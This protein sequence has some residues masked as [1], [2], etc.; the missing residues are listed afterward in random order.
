MTEEAAPYVARVLHN[1]GTRVLALV[2]D[3]PLYDD[4]ATGFS[5]PAIHGCPWLVPGENQVVLEVDEAPKDEGMPNN[6]PMFELSFFLHKLKIEEEVNV[7]HVRYPNFAETLP[8]ER[9]KFPIVSDV[10]RF[11]PEGYIPDPIWKDAPSM[12]I[13]AA[14]TPKLLQPLFELH[15]AYERR[16]V[17]AFLDLTSTKISDMVRYTGPSPDAS[18]DELAKETAEFFAMPWD[19]RPFDPN[20][21]RFRSCAQGRVAYVT[22]DERGPALFAQHKTEP[23]TTWPV[24]PYLFFEGTRWR[25][26][27]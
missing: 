20:K 8:S 18:R 24:K 5:A 14:G 11:T 15:R 9:R 6:L 12:N 4:A 7:F 17:D 10:M 1:P 23:R 21:L 3:V 2:N 13:P 22:D 27:R 26:F 16:D 25:I 19:L